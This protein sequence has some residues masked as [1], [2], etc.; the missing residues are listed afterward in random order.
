MAAAYTKALRLASRITPE[1]A[2]ALK[3]DQRAWLREN[4]ICKDR[5]CF[6]AA[7]GDRTRFLDY[8]AAHATVNSLTVTGTYQMTSVHQCVA[9]FAGND[10]TAI[11]QSGRLQI[12]Q[13]PNGSV[14]FLLNVVNESNLGIGEVEGQIPVRNNVATYTNVKPEFLSNCKLTITFKN[15]RASVSQEDGQCGFGVGVVADGNYMKIADSVNS[16]LSDSTESKRY[17]SRPAVRPAPFDAKAILGTF[18]YPAT[19]SGEPEGPN[20][21]RST[22]L[23]FYYTL[24]NT[25]DIDYYMP[26][27]AQ[28][29]VDGK[30]KHTLSLWTTNALVLDRVFIPSK[31][32]RLC[33]VHYQHPV[34]ESFGPDPRTQEELRK[35]RKLIADYMKKQ[36]YNLDGFVVLDSANRYLI[37]LPNGWDNFDPK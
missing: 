1:E 15:T 21:F 30:L 14:K 12:L 17:T 20:G 26:S 7:Y 8:Y 10:V 29:E 2:K 33:G 19:E 23:V 37:T 31:Q 6:A 34:T 4:E 27:E 22:T 3:T 25:T 24:E 5:S 18:E 16:D 35:K 32:R 9:C 13:Q 36:L 11:I 28:L